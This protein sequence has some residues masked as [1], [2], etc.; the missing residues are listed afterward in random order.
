M[1]DEK[2]VQLVAELWVDHGG[3]AEGFDWCIQSIRNAIAMLT[4]KK[5]V[6]TAAD[7]ERDEV[8]LVAELW[9]EQGGDAEGFDWCIRKIRDAIDRLIDEKSEVD[10]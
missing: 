3:D 5:D 10:E 9:V 7:A 1:N 2:L 4:A 6:C 8:D